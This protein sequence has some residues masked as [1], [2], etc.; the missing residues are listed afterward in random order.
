MRRW[1]LNQIEELAQQKTPIDIHNSMMLRVLS[2]LVCAAIFHG[3]IVMSKLL[4][5][6]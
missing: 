2:F 6:I 4:Q 5:T 1:Q 3:L